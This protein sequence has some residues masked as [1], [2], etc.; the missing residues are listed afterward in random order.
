MNDWAKG[1]DQPGLAYIF[2]REGEEGGAGP[3]AK[4]LGPERTEAIRLQLGLKAGDAVFFTA[5]E[6]TFS[7]GS[8]GWRAPG[9]GPS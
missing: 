1:E 8:Q 5:G 7:T 3:V 4:N 6:P 2:W 9:S